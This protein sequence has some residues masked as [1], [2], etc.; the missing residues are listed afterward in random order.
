[1][2]PLQRPVYPG[3][4]TTVFPGWGARMSGREGLMNSGRTEMPQKPI[5]DLRPAGRAAIVA[6]ACAA[7]TAATVEAQSLKGSRASLYRQQRMAAQHNYSFLANRTDVQRFVSSGYL[8]PIRG[9]SDYKLAS[10][11]FPYARQEVKTFLERIG[12]QYRSACGEPLVVTSLTRPHSHQPSNASDLSVHPTGMAV[13]LRVSNS[14]RCRSWLESTLLSLEKRRLVEA[15][16]ERRPPHY[17]VVVNAQPYAQ[18]AASGVTE[19]PAQM[20]ATDSAARREQKT[21]RVRSG[22]SLWQ[23]AREFG[24]SVATIKQINGLRSSQIKPG[25]SLIVP[26]R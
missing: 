14:S 2:V 3:Q 15:T 13:D 10:V 5:T 17:H 1:M 8:V 21:Y 26:T 12:S 25:Q 11:S 9:N 22:D 19:T 7:L 23:I 24:T 4:T 18:W 6:I 20:A 16:R